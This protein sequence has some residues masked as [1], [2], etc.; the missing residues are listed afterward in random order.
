MLFFSAFSCLQGWVGTEVI[1]STHTSTLWLSSCFL[2]LPFRWF[3][4]DVV[5][6]DMQLDNHLF[7]LAFLRVLL[8][9]RWSVP[10]C[11]PRHSPRQG[12]SSSRPSLSL[13]WWLR[14]RCGASRQGLRQSSSSL[15]WRLLLHALHKASSQ[16]SCLLCLALFFVCSSSALPR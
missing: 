16:P 4:T 1:A 12:N 6:L 8:Q 14:C 5:G 2:L 10:T 3:G 9:P 15:A 7:F 13:Q 11:P